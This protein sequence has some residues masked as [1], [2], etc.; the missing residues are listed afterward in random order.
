[1]PHISEDSFPLPPPRL[2]LLYPCIMVWNYLLRSTVQIGQFITYIFLCIN[3]LHKL[4]QVSKCAALSQLNLCPYEKSYIVVYLLK[5]YFSHTMSAQKNLKKFWSFSC[6]YL[7]DWSWWGITGC[8]FRTKS[9]RKSGR[10]K[11][12]TVKPFF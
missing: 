1:M 10:K 4:W 3:N 11:K 8:D 6:L 9:E 2:F 7:M 12:L 5:E